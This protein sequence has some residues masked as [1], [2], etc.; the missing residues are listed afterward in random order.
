LEF[1]AFN[2]LL[3]SSNQRLPF[4]GWILASK[5]L[6]SVGDGGR[7]L[8]SDVKAVQY[9]LSVRGARPGVVDSICGVQ[10][11]AAIERFQAG[12]MRHPD[13]L[14]EVGGMTWAQLAGQSHPPATATTP[15]KSAVAQPA[16]RRAPAPAAPVVRRAPSPAVVLGHHGLREL[17]PVS[18]L[19]KV[20]AGLQ[21]VDND[22][23]RRALGEPRP[24]LDYTQDCKPVT[25]PRMR[26]RMKSTVGLPFRANGFGPAVD[27]LALVFAEIKTKHSDVY[28][29]IT[30]A[31]MLCCRLQRSKRATRKV[32]N[33]SW[34]TAIDLGFGAVDPRGDGK[35]YFGLALIAPIFHQYGWYWGATFGT[36]DAMHFE[37]SKGLIDQWSRSLA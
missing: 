23:M 18:S 10:T 31:G 26:N 20:N 11:I 33:H 6:G 3:C 22:Y 13:G 9:L 1:F 30:T 14:V 12:F 2:Y 4:R 7:N 25:N 29:S 16:A 15:A 37:A 8:P 5:L 28:A 19:G 34:G 21:A 27:S 17:I 24:E 35:T 36:E 32:S